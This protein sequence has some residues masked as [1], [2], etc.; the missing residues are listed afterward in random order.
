MAVH[1]S[2][3]IRVLSVGATAC[4][5]VHAQL[6]FARPVRLHSQL[7]TLLLPA[8]PA[9]LLLHVLSCSVISGA[10]FFIRSLLQFVNNEGWAAGTRNGWLLSCFFFVDAYLLG[11]LWLPAA[12]LERLP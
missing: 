6:G 4:G 5:S 9:L 10:F 8:A 11:E 3:G 12:A 1:L 2:Q 7:L